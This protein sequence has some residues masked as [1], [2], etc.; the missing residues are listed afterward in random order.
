LGA[1]RPGLGGIAEQ[2]PYQGLAPDDILA[3]IQQ[4]NG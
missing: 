4:L 2:V 3:K 1:V